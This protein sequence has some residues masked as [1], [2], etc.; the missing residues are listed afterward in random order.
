MRL[1][2]GI[3]L[4]LLV[5][6][7]AAWNYLRPIPAVAATGS[8]RASEA[9]AGTPPALLWP[10]RGSG[11]IGVKGLGFIA[12]SG[13]EQP[14]PAASV[15]KVMTALLILE[16]KPLQKDQQGPTITI[17]E[18]D[19]ATY[20][21]DAANKESVAA[22]RV[23]EQI[24]ELEA[25][26]GLLIPSA[27]NLAE[28]LARWDAGSIDAFVAKMNSRAAELHLTHTKFADTSGVNPGSVSTPTDLMLLGAVAMKQEVFAQVVGMGQAVLPVAGIVYNVDRVLGQSGIV[29]IKT[30]SGLNSGANFLFAAD[31][32][33]DG[34]PVTV[35]G[36][37]MGQLTLDAAF[38]SAKGLIT[39]MQPA[40][41]VRT[42]IA[43]NQKIATYITPWGAQSDL[44]SS[45][46]VDLIEWP[47]MVLRQHLD[48]HTI[49]VDRP[50]GARTQEGNLHVVLGD[51]SLD[52]PL[53][54][55]DPMYPPGRFWRLTRLSF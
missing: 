42:V 5:A 30:G 37:V 4:L 14:I 40:L 12:S 51:Y 17:T 6:G 8:V 10:S 9:I 33:V 11:A 18:A 28:T 24:T 36:C 23:G 13:N 29:G 52:V 3:V 39:S 55:A 45:V 7:L 27:N 54:T 25:L 15:T 48:A 19:V 41:H 21:A 31:I 49:V 35:Y 32:T 20:E 16:D 26:Q 47:G 43:R 34:K 1:R 44:V 22:V 46:D 50:L 38:T 53:V 2:I